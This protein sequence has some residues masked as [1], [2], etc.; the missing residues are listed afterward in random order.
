MVATHRNR[1]LT[2]ISN[3]P[4]TS[5][6]LTVSAASVGYR[7]FASG[8]DGLSFDVSIVDG[9]DWEI[10][11][12]CIYTHSGTT[13]SRGTLADSSTGAAI[14]LT[15]SAL[16][17]DAATAALAQ[18][19]EYQLDR[20]YTFIRNSGSASQVVGDANT[21]ITTALNSV[22]SNPNGWW[23]ETNK[24]F[25]PNRAGNYLVFG[26]LMGYA[27]ASSLGVNIYKNGSPVIQGAYQAPATVKVSTVAGVAIL[28]GTTDYLELYSYQSAWGAVGN[29]A[30]N[31]FI[32]FTYLG[33]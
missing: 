4:G 9:A 19:L 26:A 30:E 27:A 22:V 2:T 25:L 28:N 3:T 5:G 14:S 31:N 23:D 32:S 18:K 1:L 16:A 29:N 8:D 15:S 7:T 21:K 11:T 10:R 17:T 12:G 20:S 24:R 33:T 6:A 13:L